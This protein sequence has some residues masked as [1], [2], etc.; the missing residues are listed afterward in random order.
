MQSYGHLPQPQAD[1][2]NYPL[3]QSNCMILKQKPLDS[4]RNHVF[5]LAQN[6]SH[7][8]TNNSSSISIH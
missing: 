5:D 4:S 2:N 8:H 6:S 7:K 3:F 1:V